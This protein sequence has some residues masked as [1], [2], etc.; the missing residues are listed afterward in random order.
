[1]ERKHEME[2]VAAVLL[3][4]RAEAENSQRVSLNRSTADLSLGTAAAKIGV[5]SKRHAHF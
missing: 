3:N 1:V 2:R 4:G 5:S